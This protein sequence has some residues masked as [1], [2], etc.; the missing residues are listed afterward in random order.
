MHLP[1]LNERFVVHKRFAFKIY[2][3]RFAR[4]RTFCIE[5]L[6][7]LPASIVNATDT[8]WLFL[9]KWAPSEQKSIQ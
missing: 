4:G 5:E 9:L 7:Q 2:E 8:K 3:E 6:Y 1:H